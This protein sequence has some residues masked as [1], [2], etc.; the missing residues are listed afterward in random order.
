MCVMVVVVIMEMCLGAA[1]LVGVAVYTSR[2]SSHCSHKT[3]KYADAIVSRVLR[4]MLVFAAYS[5]MLSTGSIRGSGLLSSRG[6]KR[7]PPV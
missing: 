1:S 6:Y 4:N 5:V 3:S 2:W 7:A